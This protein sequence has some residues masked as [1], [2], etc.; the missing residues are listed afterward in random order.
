MLAPLLSWMPGGF[1]QGV[2][3]LADD[4]DGGDGGGATGGTDGGG[5]DALAPHQMDQAF[6]E[7]VVA[8]LTSPQLAALQQRGY[9]LLGQRHNALLGRSVTLLRVPLHALMGDATS[10]VR[11]LD[12]KL[13]VDHNHYY[14]SS[15]D[16]SGP[17]AHQLVR[18]PQRMGRCAQA[19]AIGLIDTRVDPAH[20]SLRGA[21]IELL[22]LPGRDDAQRAS[23]PEHGTAV[24]S[25]LVG[26]TRELQGLLPRARL[27]AVDA[28][29]RGKLGDERMDAW[30]LVAALDALAARRVK[31]I[32]MS[33][34]G[35][36]NQLLEN[37]LD[38]VHGRQ[39]MTV[40]AVGNR[41]PQAAPQY[42][43]AYKGVIAV[44][45]V[46]SE[47]HVYHRAGRGAH[48][49]LAAPGVG[50]ATAD[51]DGTSEVRSGTSFAAPHVSA[52]IASLL[53]RKGQ[54][55]ASVRRMVL[56]QAADLGE[57]GHDSVYGHGLLQMQRL[58]GA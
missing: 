35:A 42:P 50:L 58:C 51:A 45:A 5:G 31:V 3:V 40:A 26:Q 41:G 28:F 33:F 48:V 4:G 56:G 27:L 22:G 54:T 49:D 57:P 8:G 7:I 47:R 44:T 11:A 1:S 20:A 53:T 18:W 38:R 24:A 46:N 25:L 32:N 10:E 15:T 39:I 19:P 36:A 29:H 14:R 6:R 23:S 52:A 17:V 30:D 2:A 55:P 16:A 13:L 34:A 21:S 37:A 9:V 43:S 12:S